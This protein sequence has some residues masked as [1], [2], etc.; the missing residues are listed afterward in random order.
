MYE[1]EKPY[2]SAH[3]CCP[4]LWKGVIVS[5]VQH[6]KTTLFLLQ[7]PKKTVSEVSSIF[8]CILES[9]QVWGRVSRGR[10]EFS[11]LMIQGNT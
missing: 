1:K 5:N 4:E 6:L 7:L 3:A 8:L 9:V 11:C 10:R 2:S